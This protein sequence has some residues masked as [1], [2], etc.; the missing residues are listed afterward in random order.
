MSD[1]AQLPSAALFDVFDAVQ[2]R[3]F[4]RRLTALSAAG[5]F[6]DGFDLTVIAVALPVLTK[7][8][9]I[10]PNL[11]GLIGASAV[12][13]ML[14]GALILGR[15]TDRL[16]R[17]TMYLIDL[18]CFVVFAI[19]AAFAQ[20]VWQLVLFRFLLGLGIGADYPISSTLLAEF[21]P[22][23]GRGRLMTLLG[24]TWFLGAL[25]AYLSG[26]VLAPT[27]SNSW[28][29]MLVVGAVL[30]LVII[31]LRAAIPE[32]PRWLRAQ[33]R[34]SEAAAI[35][36]G[37]HGGRITIEP[38][39]REDSR[40]I[41]LFARNRLHT[42]FFVCGFWFAYDVAFYGISVYTP[43]ILGKFTNGSLIEADAGASLIALLGLIGAGIGFLLVERWGRRPL[44]ISAFAGL[45]GAL[46]LLAL[47]PSPVLALLIGL[48]ALAELFANAGPGV[49][50]MV[51]PTELY[52]TRVRAAGTGLATAVS[53]VG[54]VLGILVFPTI[55]A[56]WG[57]SRALWLFV[58][59]A[60][61]GLIVSLVLAPE[62]RGRRLEELTG[63]T[64]GGTP[65]EVPDRA[66]SGTGA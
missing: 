58:G 28:R 3:P 66:V 19:A 39:A 47:V 11:T 9:A 1:H 15:L 42:T 22:T 40:W 29:W 7:Q 32:S 55:V 63:E 17:R 6:L 34:G 41:E 23:H 45:T 46:V 5:M 2:L 35:V 36:A 8:W 14:V 54:A 4:Q 49:L 16:G 30:A 10:S 44:I 60:L 61:L 33:G 59:A 51:Y 53:R 65:A 57:L 18:A 37:L 20:T 48:F 24:G 62:T 56:S 27:G 52:P 25:V 12:I 64:V 26:I 21:S 13:G 50:D 38:A 31:A 43:T